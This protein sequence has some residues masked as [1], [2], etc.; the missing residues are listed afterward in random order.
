VFISIQHKNTVSV[1]QDLKKKTVKKAAAIITNE[2]KKTVATRVATR[3]TSVPK[4]G[5]RQ[6]ILH[7]LCFYLIFFEV[8][9]L[10][11]KKTFQFHKPQ[12]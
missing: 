10:Y 6:E 7:C 2:N 3:A 4:Q 9:T 5:L 11:F 12:H 8:Y 1:A